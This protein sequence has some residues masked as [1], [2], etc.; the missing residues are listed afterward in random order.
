MDTPLLYIIPQ[1]ELSLDALD[2]IAFSYL[3]LGRL[4]QA[5]EL[6]EALCQRAPE[7]ENGW[8][9]LG[10]IA[11]QQRA[12]KLAM[13]AFGRGLHLTIKEKVV[14]YVKR[15]MLECAEH[16]EWG[17]V[18]QKGEVEQLPENLASILLIPWT[19]DLRCQLQDIYGDERSR[20]LTLDSRVPLTT[21]L[22][23]TAE[24]FELPSF[25]RWI[26]PFH[27]AV[28]STPRNEEDI[29]IL[30]SPILGIRHVV[31]LT[32]E[33]P[34]DE[35]WFISN[36]ITHT[37]MPI[38][39]YQCP[40]LEQVDLIIEMFQDENKLP[41]LVHCAGGKGR[42]G[43]IAACYIAAYGF[44]ISSSERVQPLMSPSAAVNALDVIRPRLSRTPQQDEF[45][46]KWISTVWKRHSVLPERMSEPPPCSLETRG[47]IPPESDLLVLCGLQ[48][49][50]A[51]NA[52]TFYTHN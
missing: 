24:P 47:T 10:D 18:F 6:A 17:H 2:H 42:T 51:V 33:T 45:V 1:S 8:T 31:T 14:R 16:T 49:R 40:T 3:Q 25:F 52:V 36:R 35:K 39:H 27:F 26:V 11:L 15:R 46:G 43:T 50:P 21:I 9:R 38:E 48:G 7:S 13:L 22:P 29:S 4:G 34:L 23:N 41:L 30:A 44:N 20:S 5:R 19:Q 32:E 37:H 12:Y 28:M